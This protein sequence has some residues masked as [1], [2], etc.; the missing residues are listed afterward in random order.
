MAS[1]R[2]DE[3]W[4]RLRE[5]TDGKTKSERLAAQILLLEGYSVDPSHP[6]GGPDGGRD[7]ICTRHGQRWIMAVFFPR[8]QLSFTK[9]FSKLKSDLGKAKQH[10]PVGVAFITNQ[11]LTL[12]NRE[13]L[14]DFATS[15]ELI[16]ELISHRTHMRDPRPTINAYGSSRI[17]RLISP[18]TFRINNRVT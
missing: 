9:I 16:L 4:H 17:F 15:L 13:K 6:L 14:H 8:G 10:T 1:Y 18:V 7:A 2:C 11:E 12:T 5:W 3:T